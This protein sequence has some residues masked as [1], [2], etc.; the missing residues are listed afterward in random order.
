MW[1]KGIEESRRDARINAPVTA[2]PRFESLE[3][4]VLLSL[5]GVGEEIAPP[6][7]Q[8]DQNG[9][10][11]YTYNAET[12]EGAFDADAAPTFFI[13]ADG[14]PALAL[15]SPTHGLTFQLKFTLDGDGNIVGGVE[16]DDLYV[17]G[18]IIGFPGGVP[19]VLY[20]GVL[21]TGEIDMFGFLENGTNDQFDARITPT[22]GVMMDLFDGKDIGLDMTSYTPPAGTVPYPGFADDFTV[23]FSG[24]T[25][26]VIA[27]IAKLSS[28]SGVVFQDFNNDG[29]ID[30]NEHAIENATLTLTGL[31]DRGETVDDTQQTDAWGLYLFENLRPGTYTITETQPAGYEDGL[32]VLGYG[33]V[34]GTTPVND[35]YVGIPLPGSVNATG[36]NFAELLIGGEVTSGQTATIGFWQNRN[37][38]ELLNALPGETNLSTWLATEFPNMY[39]ASA[40]ASNLTGMSNALVA[41][42]YRDTLFKA[43]KQKG[44]GPAK[45]GAQVMA[46]AFAVYVTNRGLAGD[47]AADYGFL[48]S[49][50]GLG[51][52]TFD[53]AE[54]SDAFLEE[55]ETNT[56]LTILRILQETN[57]RTVDGV[58][59][60]LDA[61]LRTLANEVYSMINEAG[62]I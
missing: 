44:S 51:I 47:T 53:V 15:P 7:L 22:G 25:Q 29:E 21:L 34:G 16:G 24:G 45:V 52:A 32:E 14:S 57:E 2:V 59:Y 3:G 36:Y 46:T 39:G 58:L 18:Q 42:Y 37:G 62:D 23:N 38:Q 41:S 12:Q 10:L 54:Y 33:N 26:G 50:N 49:D 9:T 4:R 30:A 56:I 28:L 61:I 60:D 31:N 13:L 6:A 1:N 43:K 19:T 48:V 11:T 27:P 8:Y 17:T 35:T 40:G 5:L 55:G 20:D